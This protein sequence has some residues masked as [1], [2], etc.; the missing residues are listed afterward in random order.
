V[1]LKEG[2]R[3]R[4]AGEEAEVY[5]VLMILLY[6]M[7]DQDCRWCPIVRMEMDGL[8]PMVEM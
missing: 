6:L 3:E 1:D 8:V 4:F 5:L 2:R 7:T